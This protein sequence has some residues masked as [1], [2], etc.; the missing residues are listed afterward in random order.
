[1]ARHA[2]C[3][4][5]DYLAVHTWYPQS[6]DQYIGVQISSTK[7]SCRK[8]YDSICFD[9][10][11]SRS[12]T[13]LSPDKNLARILFLGFIFLISAQHTRNHT[14]NFYDTRLLSVYFFVCVSKCLIWSFSVVGGW[15]CFIWRRFRFFPLPLTGFLFVEGNRCVG[16]EWVAV[17]RGGEDVLIIYPALML[18]PLPRF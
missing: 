13:A 2:N 9:P 6:L 1:M 8:T 4:R 14:P 5:N 7:K 15:R 16:I 17:D 10:F 3:C 12:F 18:S 11:F